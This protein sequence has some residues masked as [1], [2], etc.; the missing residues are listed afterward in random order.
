MNLYITNKLKE[1]IA[2][3]EIILWEGRFCHQN[4]NKH[5]YSSRTCTSY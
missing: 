5:E 3:Q 2:M 4:L 1:V